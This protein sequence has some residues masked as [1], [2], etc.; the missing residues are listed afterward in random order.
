[1]RVAYVVA[2]VEL[3]HPARLDSLHRGL[4]TRNDSE[5]QVIELTRHVIEHP[6]ER[7]QEGWGFHCS[8]LDESA[9]KAQLRSILS[10]YQPDAVVVTGYS[11]P[12][13]RYT[14][15]WARR[16]GAVCVLGSDTN[17]QDRERRTFKEIVKSLWVRRRVDSAFVAGFDSAAYLQGLGL[18]A[19]RIWRG[20]DVVDN[21]FFSS[22]V[23][24][25]RE[26][27]AS[28]RRSMGAPAQY[29]LFVGRLAPE[30]NVGALLEAYRTYRTVHGRSW[31][32]LIAGSGP[33]EYSLKQK[34]AEMKLPGTTWIGYVRPERLPVYYGLAAALVLPSLSE[35]WG[36]VVNEAMASGLPVLV[37]NRCGCVPDL[38]RPGINGYTFDPE[39]PEQLA[40]LMGR[41]ESDK[42]RLGEMGE[43]SRQII[44]EYTPQTWAAT[45]VECIVTT[46]DRRRRSSR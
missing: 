41:I 14:A 2:R 13:M 27:E 4:Q 32:L 16:N 42:D 37:S 10:A 25:A 11:H 33:E 26:H 31:G 21:D 28:I 23:E 7:R 22:R 36:L 30:K 35:P 17:R 40:R 20:Y 46:L 18:P 8:T 6:V 45:L 3:Y 24:V 5:L 29:F 43:H 12:L 39:H 44:A 34:A 9:P 38:V 19:D 15:A 1:M